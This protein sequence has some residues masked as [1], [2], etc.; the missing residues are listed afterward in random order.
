[1]TAVWRHDK[2]YPPRPAHLCRQLIGELGHESICGAIHT[3]ANNMVEGDGGRHRCQHCQRLL[4][5]NGYD[6]GKWGADGRRG[7]VSRLALMEFEDDA[8]LLVNGEPEKADY[9]A[10]KEAAP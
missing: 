8:G 1:M 2:W 6:L 3:R 5:A 7:N 10:L 9:D 4:I